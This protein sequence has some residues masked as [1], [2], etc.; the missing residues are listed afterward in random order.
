MDDTHTALPSPERE[1]AGRLPYPNHSTSAAGAGTTNIVDDDG[2]HRVKVKPKQKRNKP[3]LSCLEC[4]S[5]P[6]TIGN[7]SQHTD[8]KWS[9]LSVK[10]NVTE[11]GHVWPV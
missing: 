8:I 5:E 11:D 4:V 1:D 3:T 6:G 2:P 10:P 9:R 7:L